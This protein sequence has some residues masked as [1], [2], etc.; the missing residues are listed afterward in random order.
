MSIR[1]TKKLATLATFRT[2]SGLAPDWM[3]DSSPE[4]V[5]VHDGF[6]RRNRE[7][8]GD[9]DVDSFSNQLVDGRNT[10]GCARDFDHQVRPID[11][12]PQ[13]PRLEQGLLRLVREMGR[14]LEAD[15]AVAS[16]GRVV[17]R[18]QEVGRVTHICN[19]EPLVDAFRILVAA[20]RCERFEHGRVVSTRS[21]RVF[22]DR[23]V[24][25]HTSQSVS[26]D[27]LMQFAT[28][29][30]AP[31]DRVQPDGLTERRQRPHRVRRLNIE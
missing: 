14:H 6:V 8:Q 3:Y 24:G 22:E 1:L 19:G 27:Q 20:R 30:E 26:R 31:A 18:A 12:R 28:R 7:E 21:N 16:P 23:R 17:D 4:H 25:G 2:R 5:R 13:A 10:A 11:C 9:V 15:I 29:N